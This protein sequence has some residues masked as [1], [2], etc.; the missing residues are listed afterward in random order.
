[1]KELSNITAIQSILIKLLEQFDQICKKH[2]ITYW[3]SNG[4]LL[5][6]VK[7]NQ[8][9]P[10]DDDIDVI[11]KRSDYEKLISLDDSE[12]GCNTLICNKKN[13]NWKYL[14]AKFS[15]S[16]TLVFE[17]SYDLGCKYGLSIDIFPLDYI[18]DNY[19]YAKRIANKCGFITRLYC[20]STSPKFIT[21]K[22]GIK[23]IILFFIYLTSRI[24][25]TSFWR[26]ILKIKINKYSKIT[27]STLLLCLSFAPYGKKE[28]IKNE[29][30][31]DTVYLMFNGKKY[32]CIIGY[33]EYLSSMYN[34]YKLELPKDK[35][36]SNHFMRVYYH[37]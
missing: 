36:K 23:R 24:F 18:G 20:A 12:F 27:S 35:Q 31:N 14:Y 34:D 29:W 32:P 30:L 25:G 1:M 9:I 2:T 19:N 10:W 6:A 13:P 26:K 37:D 7:Y 16:N 28:I 11:M 33:H 15:D 8:M 22:K 3:L 5:G 21:S 4:S 17:Q